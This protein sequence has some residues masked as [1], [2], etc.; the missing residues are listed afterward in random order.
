MVESTPIKCLS[1]NG[2]TPTWKSV[3]CSEVWAGWA[4]LTGGSFSLFALA[5]RP[6]VYGRVLGLEPPLDDPV[7]VHD[8][9]VVVAGLRRLVPAAHDAVGGRE[10]HQLRQPR[11]SGYRQT[12]RF[13][14]FGLVSL[15]NGGSDDAFLSLSLSLSLASSRFSRLSLGLRDGQLKRMKAKKEWKQKQQEEFSKRLKFD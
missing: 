9:V 15:D 10:R 2:V 3:K 14:R 7:L 13:D 5:V 6:S 8:D 1:R 11:Q 4:V 12:G